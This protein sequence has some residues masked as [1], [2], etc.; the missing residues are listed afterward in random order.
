MNE[1]KHNHAEH[2]AKHHHHEQHT[3]DK[4]HASHAGYEGG[5]PAHEHVGHGQDFLKRF[6]VSLLLS[7]PVLLFSPMIQ[8][9]FGFTLS[10]PY[11]QWVVSVLATVIFI[12]GGQPFFQGTRQE[13]KLQSPAMMT[14]VSLAISVSY[15]YSVAIVLGLPG[16][17]FFWEMVTLVDI[18]LLGHYIEMKSSVAAGNSLRSLTQLLP[19]TAI[20]IDVD[21]Q[22]H[23]VA[24]DTLNIQD[25][26]LV[27]PGEKI[28]V[29]GIIVDGRST[30]DESMVTG[31]SVPVLKAFHDQVIGGTINGDGVLK[32][33]VERLGAETYLSQVV[34]LVE[35]A[36]ASKSKTQRLADQAAKYLFYIAVVTAAI[37]GIVWTL[38]GESLHFVLERVVTVIVVACPHA[39][40][41][42]IPLVTSISTTLSAQNGLLIKN[43]AAFEGA[44]NIDTVVFDKTGTLT[45]GKFIVTDI[46]SYGVAREDMLQI[47][48]ALEDNSTHPIAKAIVQYAQTQH[49]ERVNVQD[50]KNNPGK[51][52]AAVLHGQTI[53]VVSPNQVRDNNLAFDEQH[54]QDLANQGK[55][56]VY[57]LQNQQ[58][59]GYI[60]LQDVPK[61][62]AREAIAE[63]KEMNIT[64]VML[65]GDNKIVAQH[66]AQEVG[67]ETVIA[68]VLPHEKNQY[69]TQ[70]QKDGKRVAMTGDG[71]NDAPS[72]AGA[73]LG[74]AIGAGT[75]I[76]IETA[77]VIL[78]RSNPK[79]VVHLLRLSRQTYRKMMQNLIW[80][81]VYNIIAL[82][83]AAGVLF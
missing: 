77:D 42:A 63:L 61:D 40:G 60:A 15:L 31:E 28:P 20:L 14:L 58:V 53:Q 21:G 59:L 13:L 38:Q 55:T 83:L 26:V 24:I 76:A 10:F 74:I 67:I 32:V 29:D 27:K 23:Q 33:R 66:I 52:I 36:S 70:L 49:I 48:Y 16:H 81:T 5:S 8:S 54:Y 78:V 34:K 44:R 4:N 68:E 17:D 1:H 47:A 69:I 18:M 80:A 11:D 3:D 6:V 12:Y 57:V 9:F 56:I 65:T 62:E 50:Y 71:I 41:L 45:E 75:D 35:A 43:R 73:D 39:L 79:D 7:I 37:T 51:G 72:L 19:S 25:V 22:M 2:D 82:P 30:L 64:S 46:D